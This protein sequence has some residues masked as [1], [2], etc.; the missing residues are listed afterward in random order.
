MISVIITAGGAG[1]RMLTDVPKQFLSLNGK[2]VIA[3]SINLFFGLSEVKEI[4]VV[5]GSDQVNE[6]NKILAKE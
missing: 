4:I 3:Q 5:I 1:K 6:L 2:P